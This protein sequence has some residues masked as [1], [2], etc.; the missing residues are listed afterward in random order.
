[1]SFPLYLRVG[2][3][4]IHPHWIFEALAYA[5]AFQVYLALRRRRGDAIDPS[6]RW[7]V[8]AAAAVGAVLGSKLLYWFEDPPL[9]LAHWN[10]LSFLMSG[11][12]V[13]GA[14]IGGLFAVEWTKRQLGVVQRTGDLFAIPLCIGI[15]IGRIGCFLTGLEDHTAGSATSLPWAVNYGDGVLRHPTQ[16][17]EIVFVLALAVLL[18]TVSRKPFPDGHLFKIFMVGYFSFRLAIDFLKPDVR[19]FLRL[20]SI[21]WACIAMLIY[22]SPD[23]HRWLHALIMPASSAAAALPQSKETS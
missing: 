1:M 8:I 5:V 13:V 6:A 19:V 20:S 17:Y 22:Y 7:R 23:L 12:T 11:K 9:T 14:L 2:A 3:L 18:W 4:R 16:I 10:D 21:Q 15:A